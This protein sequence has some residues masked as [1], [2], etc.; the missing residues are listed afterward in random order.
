MQ[1]K[2]YSAWR[3]ELALSLTLNTSQAYTK[4]QPALAK[5]ILNSSFPDPTILTYYS[6]PIVSSDDKIGQFQPR[7]TRPQVAE[8][9]ALCKELFNWDSKYGMQRFMR[10]FVPGYLVWLMVHEGDRFEDHDRGETTTELKETKKKKGGAGAA[11]QSKRKEDK[12]GVKKEKRTMTDFFKSTK[13]SSVSTSKPETSSSNP[14]DPDSSLATVISISE[15]E[16]TPSSSTIPHKSLVLDI[17]SSR[18]HF[19]TDS[20]PELR[21]SYLPST[22]LPYHPLNFNLSRSNP[23][24]SA[25]STL[26]SPTKSTAPVP[27]VSPSKR[28]APPTSS[29]G[30]S[31]DIDSDGTEPRVYNESKWSPDEV[32]RIWIPEVYVRHTMPRWVARFEDQVD[33]KKSP[34]KIKAVGKAKGKGGMTVGSMEQFVTRRTTTTTTAT[35]ATTATTVGLGASTL[36]GAENGISPRKQQIGLSSLS[37]LSSPSRKFNALS[38][39]G[40][41]TSP[42]TAPSQSR[43][44]QRQPI[45]SPPKFE[46]PMSIKIPTKS[47]VS[48][49]V[50]PAVFDLEPSSSVSFSPP[51]GASSKTSLKHNPYSTPTKSIP[52]WGLTIDAE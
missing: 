17:H 1:A 10:S 23:P 27:P 8:V 31:E 50:L 36:D 14:L 33:A 49:P 4:K 37:P 44:Q 30:S 13:S 39:R 45:P 26:T 51:P 35:T 40:T 11:K 28:A 15:T 16:T 7:W 48:P 42:L 29:D 46:I 18:T 6:R 34:K 19:S 9:A 25:A 12:E 20:T 47:T 38:L 21:L 24:L 22:I 43:T 52:R 32:E 3:E 5:R 41:T 2:D